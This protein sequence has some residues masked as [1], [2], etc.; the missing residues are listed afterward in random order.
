MRRYAG[1]LTLQ[2]A[3]LFAVVAAAVFATVGFYLVQALVS[4]LRERDDADLLDR[5]AYI[6]HLLEET[7]TANSVKENPHRFLDA[8]DL[9][10]GMLLEIRTGDG[11]LLTRN[12]NIS[13]FASSPSDVIA[14][15]QPQMDDVRDTVSS[16]GLSVRVLRAAGQVGNSADVVHITLAHMAEAR[17]ALLSAYRLKV[18]VAVTIGAFLTA[19]LGYLVSRRSLGKVAKLANQARAITV[20]NLQ[21]RLNTTDVPEELRE[22]ADSF[23]DVLS[24]LQGSFQNLSQ[25]SADLAHDMRTPLNN[26]MVQTQVALSQT[27]ERDEYEELLTSHHEEYER[28]VRMVETMLFLARADHDEIVLTAPELDV[29]LELHRIAE[30]FEGPASDA[31]VRFAVAG[32]GAVVADAV[33]FRR[34]VGNLV[35]NALRYTPRGSVINLDGEQSEKGMTITVSNPGIGIDGRDLP[36]LFERFYRSDKSR[37]SSGTSAGLGLA[38]VKSIMKLHGGT[39]AVHSTNDRATFTLFF[40]STNTACANILRP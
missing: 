22:M 8:V 28:L 3:G 32:T 34:A 4:Q 7:A 16:D 20:E 36:R 14:S 29:S 6:R 25:F 18:F 39:A 1:S 13:R 37:S 26:L 31:G 38:I 5:V 35:S 27:R 9:R 33:L 12:A 23:N 15:R 40:P 19:F 11:R 24:R 21:L 17:A 10:G 2:L 30:Y